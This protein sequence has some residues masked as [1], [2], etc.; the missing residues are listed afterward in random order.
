[1]SLDA[2]IIWLSDYVLDRRTVPVTY[3]HGQSRPSWFDIANLPPCNCYDEPGA[4]ASV[5][6]IESL[7]TAEVRSGTPPTRI[8]LIGFSQGGAV[9]MM[10]A[11]TTLQELGGVASLSGWIPQPS[12][13]AML[14]LEPCLPVF[15]AHGIPDTEV[16]ISYGEESVDFL[17]ESLHISDDKLVFKKYEQL[18]HTVNDGELDDLAVWLTQL[19]G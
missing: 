12:R 3:N 14:Q 6:T 1:M 4:A 17:Q 16:P 13:Q 2:A 11:L 5:A 8:A 15:W 19:L 18:E 9:A 7:V 10:T